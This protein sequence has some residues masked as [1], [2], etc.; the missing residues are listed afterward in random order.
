MSAHRPDY[1]SGT[2]REFRGGEAEGLARGCLGD[3]FDFIQ[4]A[5]RLDRRHPILDVALAGAHADLDRLLGDRLVREDADPQL[6][7]A[8]DVARDGAAAGLDLARGER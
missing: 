3:T 8:L 1:E 2:H 7:A 4:H 6:A 5:T